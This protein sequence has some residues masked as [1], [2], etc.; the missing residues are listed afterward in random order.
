MSRRSTG[1]QPSATSRKCVWGLVILAAFAL[2]GRSAISAQSTTSATPPER[3]NGAP[4]G[5]L[6][7]GTR[8][9]TISLVTSQNATC[10]YAT[11]AGTAYTAMTA[12]FATTG[13]MQH[14]T[15]VDGLVSGG[16][17][18]YYVR[19][20]GTNGATNSDD[21]RITFSVATGSAP[22]Q[23]PTPTPTS[24]PTSPPTPTPNPDSTTP[25]D[26]AAPSVTITSPLEGTKVAGTATIRAF[27]SDKDGITS[28]TFLVDGTAIGTDTDS[29]YSIRWNTSDLAPGSHTIRAQARDATGKVGTSRAVTVTVSNDR[30]PSE[31]DDPP[32]ASSSK[33][34]FTPSVPDTGVLRYVLDIFRSGS[35]L[36]SPVATQDLGKPA[37]KSGEISA[38]VSRTL[39]SLPDG[40]YVAT[41]TAVGSTDGARSE[42]SPPFVVASARKTS[43]TALSYAPDSLDPAP[44]R[45]PPAGEGQPSETSDALG[46]N[47]TL[48]V[49]DASTSLVTV[50]DATTGDVLATVP[51]GL[52]PMGIV[53]PPGLNKVYVADEGSDTVS[54]LSKA[55]MTLVATVP[56]PPPFGRQP[57][58][59]STSP[60]GR[61]VYVGER[62][63][64]VVDVIDTATDL[65]SARFAAGSPG[66]KTL[67]V[68]PAPAGELLY[69]VN[70]G[71]SP[72]PSTLT[73]LEASTGTVRWQLPV[74]DPGHFLLGPDGRTGVLS[75][76]TGGTITFIDLERRS[77]VNEIDL[78]GSAEIDGLQ[79][80]GDGRYLVATLR[81][82]PAGVLIMDLMETA[83]VSIVPLRAVASL[84]APSAT[85][86][87][88]I[89][90]SDSSEVP[91]G[92]IMVDAA[93]QRVVQQFRLPGRGTPRAAVLDRGR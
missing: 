91:A 81:T 66:S 67:A 18:T 58:H 45:R 10:R 32:A 26:A 11:T 84:T 76:Q 28:V 39:G 86:P 7:A 69:A 74:D 79:L 27:A 6:T 21:F 41:V 72:S 22:T 59:M 61:F 30:S 63:S 80:T 42:P 35:D 68:V 73:A 4:T 56:L 82:S 49:T 2:F 75:H 57:H 14:S 31:P 24:P 51:V 53:V 89:P 50:F 44:D 54:V 23:P 83:S 29:P 47:G 88:Y 3:S 87:L 64:N 25:P 17:Y 92:V 5:T 16:R 77:I 40:T 78:G 62:G 8:Q 33:A 48:W 15:P 12:A 71:M 60:D 55:T 93:T 19:C 34:I 37:V 20:R 9:G 65:V 38:D 52:R 43:V 13:A 85:E 1:G 36:K 46:P 70:R 90:V